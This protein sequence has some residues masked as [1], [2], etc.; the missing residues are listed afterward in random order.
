MASEHRS[1]PGLLAVAAGSVAVVAGLDTTGALDPWWSLFVDDLAQT[2][3]ALAAVLACWITAARHAGRQRWWRLWMGAGAFGWLLGQLVW[4]WYQLWENVGL[5]TPSLADAGYLILPVLALAALVALAAD[6]PVHGMPR[7][8]PGRVAMVLDGLVIVG[9]LFVISW[10]TV[11]GPVVR[12]GAASRAEYLIALAYPIT[13]LVLTVIV[14]LLIGRANQVQLSV[15]GAGLFFLSLGDSVFAYQVA[16]GADSMPAAADLGFVAGFALVA[17]AAMTAPGDAPVWAM[18]PEPR[19]GRLLLPYLPVTAMGAVLVGQRLG[20][21]PADTAV[22]AVATL[23]LALLVIRQAVTLAQIAGLVASRARLV[24]ATDESRRELE[25]NLHDGVQQRL[26]SLA[27]DIRRIEADVPPECARVRRELADVVQGI[28]GT[29]DEVRELSRGVH[30]AILTQG[31]LRPGLRALAR[32]SAVAVELDVHLDGRLPEPVEVAAYYVVAEALTNAAKHSDAELVR[33][34]VQ[35]R[36]G[37][38]YLSVDDDGQGGANP[39]RGTGLL[40]LAD[41]CE[42]IGGTLVVDSPR[43]YGTHLSAELPLERA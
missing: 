13:D 20:G 42:A 12:A 32:R 27:L 10:A 19:W 35:V 43:G 24:L 28:N 2:L 15:L 22:T 18:R 39:R 41:R 37:G 1:L 7:H 40:G 8:L 30:P 21:T 17:V 38:L 16:I 34:G 14:V 23:V 36:G 11:L 29:V 33:V 31:G 25:R 6:R 4:S 3:A 9:A 26:I 5:P